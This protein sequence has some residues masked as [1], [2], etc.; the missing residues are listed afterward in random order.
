MG[1]LK[2]SIVVAYLVMGYAGATGLTAADP[3]PIPDF[4]FQVLDNYCLSCHDDVEFKGEINLDTDTITWEEEASQELWKR[5]IKMV[6]K[7]EMPPKKKKQPTDTERSELVKW[8]DTKLSKHQPIGGSEIRRLNSR[9][10]EH[11]IRELFGIDFKLPSGFPQDNVAHGF[12]N[13]AE[14]LT[15]SG[16]LMESY[17]SV[18]TDLAE[19]LF[20]PARKHV[21]VK[22]AKI[23]AKDFTYAY[24]S[25]LLLEEA[26][27]LVSSSDPLAHSATWPT[28]YEAPATGTYHLTIDLSALNPEPGIPVVA[29]IYAVVATE[30]SQENIQDLRK[31]ARVEI[32]ESQGQ[33]F[34]TEVI[35]EK[36]ETIA[37][38]YPTAVIKEDAEKI[39]SYLLS[40][41]AREPALAA[42]YKKVNGPVARGRSGLDHLY[43]L[44]Q[45]G[46]LPAPPEGEELEK[47][48]AKVSKDKRVV[49]ETFSYKLFEEGP[50]LEIRHATLTGP[51]ALTASKEEL[52]WKEHTE[53]LLGKQHGRESESDVRA[54]LR[55]FLSQAFRRPIKEDLLEEYVDTVLQEKETSG[56]IDSGYHL[57]IRTALTSPYFLYRG[58][59]DGLLD[60]YDM[61]SRLSYFLSSAPPDRQLFKAAKDGSL[62]DPD[63]LATQTRRLIASQKFNAFVE[64]FLGQ[65]LDLNELESLVPD[66]T[67]FESPKD[68][69]YTDAEKEAY[70][71][72]AH[73]VFREILSE[74]RP[75]EDFIDP[76]FT[77]TTG[78]V[79]RFIYNLPQFDKSRKND[80]SKMV[81]VPLERGGRVGG[82][83]G[84]AGVMTA[85][86]NGVDTQPVLRGV[87]V[88]E[89][90]LGDPAPPPPG[91]V[92]ALTPD[93]S[94]AKTPREMLAAHMAEESCAG[95]HKKIDPVG[96]VLESFDPVG[97][98]RSEYPPPRNSDK[99]EKNAGLPV[100]TKG[101]LTDG[102][103][104]N[105]VTDLKQYLRADIAPFA[106]C[107]SE[108]LLTYATGRTMNYSDHKLIR[109]TVQ[110]VRQKEGGFQDLLIALVNSESFRIR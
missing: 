104:L 106:E 62:L 19:K 29:D 1:V 36:G 9:E 21:P 92:P 107:I 18:A 75:V 53:H 6:G 64:S 2:K 38:H 14:A 76:D 99:K 79:G 33:R 52:F 27:R 10:Y 101:K 24:S 16:T 17:S 91:S 110:E 97:R 23:P 102:T 46:D 60:E 26:M 5:V 103:V 63:I 59:N 31:I 40:L 34:E 78:A 81:R 98:W 32:T 43:E 71:R 28:H 105:D 83:L 89:N 30:A 41:F 67:L 35:L 109:K 8:L 108:K 100:E 39:K 50:A 7:G 95:C 82:I 90:I 44:I 37:F 58:F 93:T 51:L 25:G 57:A 96:F 87:W 73:L 13:Q 3:E 48:L 74:N 42:A 4:A 88:L 84:M 12:D 15:L 45:A 55:R 20:P 66:A 61:A 85:T 11:S 72:E 77:Y 70:I 94:Q 56:R 68:F 47:L 22:T 80:N 69:T 54:F 86:A 65:W 49:T